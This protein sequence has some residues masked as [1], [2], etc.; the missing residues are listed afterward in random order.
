MPAARLFKH[1]QMDK[2]N[3]T[4][5]RQLRR[6]NVDMAARCGNME[7]SMYREEGYNMVEGVANFKYMGQ[8]LDQT[9]DDW[10]AVW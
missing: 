10:P 3:K 1:R 9:N 7:F 6:I 4:M 8:T 5:E 2:C